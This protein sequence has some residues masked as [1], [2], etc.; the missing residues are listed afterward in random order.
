MCLPVWISLHGDNNDVCMHKDICVH[1]TFTGYSSADTFLLWT[2][3]RMDVN[4][5]T[6]VM[7]FLWHRKR[8]GVQEHEEASCSRHCDIRLLLHRSF[9]PGFS[10]FSSVRSAEPLP[11]WSDYWEVCEDIHPI[12]S[13]PQDVRTE[14]NQRKAKE[15]FLSFSLVSL[16]GSVFLLLLLSRGPLFLSFH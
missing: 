16:N 9:F 13:S 8:R 12:T 10:S 11:K 5:C 2:C 3:L 15:D 14:G 7:C 6:P 1:A 4:V